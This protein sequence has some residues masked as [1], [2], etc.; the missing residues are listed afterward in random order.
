MN[1]SSDQLGLGRESS[2]R[3]VKES[4]IP[5]I[6]IVLL[7]LIACLI[8]ATLHLYLELGSTRSEMA[9]QLK[10]HEEQIAQLEGAVNRASNTVDTKVSELQGAVRTAQ[11]EL[12]KTAQQVESKFMGQTQ[13][14]AKEIEQ[15]KQQQSKQQQ[16]LSEVD[17]ELEQLKEVTTKTG[18]ELGSLSG[19]V[20]TVSE[21]SEKN[22]DDL[23]ATIRDLKSVKG[24][25]GVQ[26]GLIATNA[27]ELNALRQL[28]ER[29]Y[30]EF[31]LR[32]EKA[33]K[34][35]GNVSIR[36]RKA[37]EKRNKYNI[38]IWVDDKKME[39]KDKNLL[40][41]VQFYS[42]GTRI[43]SE[44]VVNKLEKDHIVGYVSVPKLQRRTAATGSGSE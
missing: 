16:V 17:G 12:S 34:R 43:P 11:T 19:K 9:G 24:D 18:S 36:L 23:E 20:A 37:D 44:I 28:G 25:L 8:G 7:V 5:P 38:E 13:K 32:K 21:L 39:K 2:H 42:Y 26:S 31:D 14:L 1:D 40:E 3:E 10:L 15:A 30:F 29:D 27:G 4:R 41:P 22:R 33:S 6:A 35:Y